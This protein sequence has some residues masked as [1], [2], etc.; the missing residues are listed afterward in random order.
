MCIGNGR[1]Y[2]FTYLVR[3]ELIAV[4]SYDEIV[5]NTVDLMVFSITHMQLLLVTRLHLLY[6]IVVA[7]FQWSFVT[8]FDVI[9]HVFPY[10]I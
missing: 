2:K 9:F 1:Y 3:Y 4:L 8:N 7:I 10:I 5:H 6:S